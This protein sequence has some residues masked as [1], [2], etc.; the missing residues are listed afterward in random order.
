MTTPK[1]PP[2]RLV[3]AVEAVRARWQR[4]GQRMVPGPIA[5]LELS[6]AA[7]I[8]QAIHVA[9]RFG[10]A[11]LLTEGSLPAAEIAERAGTDPD[12]THRLLRLLASYSIF[13]QE[14][15]GRFRLTPMASALRRDVPGSMREIALLVGDPV[16]REHWS[17]L[18][19][20]VR[21][22]DPVIPTLRGM[23]GYEF[24]AANPDFAEVFEGGMGNLSKL[25]TD[26]IIAAYDFSRYHT[27]VDVFGGGGALLAA[28]LGQAE[29]SRG[30]LVDARAEKLGAEKVF[31]EAGVAERA[32]VDL[33]ALFDPPPA[34]G[35]A[36]LM[37]HILHE[38]PEATA[39]DLLR[40]VRSVIGETG[41]LLVLEFIVPEGNGQHPAK[42][43]D[44]W[45]MVLM[46]GKER[47]AAEYADLLQRAGFRLDRVVGTASALSII[48]AVPV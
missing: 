32:T 47:T 42:L 9:A 21:T 12:S 45:L 25:E 1:V 6:M 7:M 4:I 40:N 31:Q 43:V 48:E 41:R 33:T 30:V 23:G 13:A 18:V 44:L 36:Y 20:A 24:L 22:G 35:D 8:T 34:G 37:K 15:D 29:R 16:E 14:K 38:W 11:D 19:S 5:L 3:R 27:V 46:G 10:F 2:A 26:P 17:H 39:L 28:I